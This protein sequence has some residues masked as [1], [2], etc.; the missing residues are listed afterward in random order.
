LDEKTVIIITGPTAVG[1]T[2]LAISLAQK[3]STEIISAD[4]RQCYIE[5][6]IGVAKPSA[7]QLR[8]VLHHFI[9]SY[10]IHDT[11]NAAVFEQYALSK[12][13]EIFSKHRT[14]VMVGGTGLYIKAFTQGLDDIPEIDESFRQQIIA[15]YTANGIE[16][17]QSAVQ[18]ED[19][20]YFATGEIK[21]PHRLMRA[22]EVKRATGQSIRQFQ[23]RG[24][25]PRPFTIKQYALDLPKTELH[26]N[27]NHRV[28]EMMKDGLLDEVTAL[29]PYRYLT[30]LQTVGYKELFDYIDGKISL[31]EATDQIKKNTR[32]YAKRQLT[33]YRKDP[34]ITW[35]SPHDM[36]TII[37]TY[38]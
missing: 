36:N 28:D 18:L 24:K 11:V 27:I 38:R 4:S 19:P 22:L 30:A 15:D 6:N 26:S 37:D 10:S 31:D 1:K 7:E 5:M 21:N 13:N 17:L 9:S 20:E 35:I 23:L 14:L 3:L 32:A 29:H 2:S 34:S 25:K 8:L 33:W 12:A 16:W